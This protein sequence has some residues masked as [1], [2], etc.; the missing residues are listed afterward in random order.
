MTDLVT[1][2]GASFMQRALFAVILIAT[3]AAVVGV[4]LNL[5]RKSV[6]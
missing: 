2:F 3:V 5:D 6:V 1:I 4:A